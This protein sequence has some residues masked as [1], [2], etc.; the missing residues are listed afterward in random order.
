MA[1]LWCELVGTICC[2]RSAPVDWGPGA[3]AGWIGGTQQHL[4]QHLL[5]RAVCNLL[6]PGCRYFGI[7]GRDCAE[8]ASDR[9]VRA[10]MSALGWGKDAGLRACQPAASPH[11]KCSVLARTA[12]QAAPAHARA[13]V[14]QL[15]LSVAPT[16]PTP[17]YPP[18]PWAGTETQRRQ[19]AGHVGQ[20]LWHVRRRAEGLLTHGH[21]GE[22]ERASHGH[23]GERGRASHGHG[24]ERERA[25]PSSTYRLC[26][27]TARR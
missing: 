19:A 2:A 14:L 24:G 6:G 13:G 18:V 4:Q 21:G 25:S 26:C 10:L 16:H 20:Q 23:G 9:M 27:G 1:W 22:R 17:P 8:V 7:M 15:R 5:W 3:P 11:S 12:W